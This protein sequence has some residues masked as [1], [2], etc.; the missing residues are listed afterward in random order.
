M[1]EG[2][3]DLKILCW[4]LV[5]LTSAPAVMGR[6]ANGPWLKVSAWCLLALIT[7]ANLWLLM[8]LVS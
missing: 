3:L 2:F 5:R 1:L 8:T 6:F 4:P 7:L